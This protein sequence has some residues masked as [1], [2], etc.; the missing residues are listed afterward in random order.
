M[1]VISDLSQ[2]SFVDIADRAPR[3]SST[4][5]SI[6]AGGT[7]SPVFCIHSIDGRAGRYAALAAHID[8]DRPVYGVETSASVPRASS[9]SALA[10]RYADD[11]LAVRGNGPINLLGVSFGGLLAHAVAVALQLGGLA[12]NSLALLGSRRAGGRA[13][14]RHRRGRRSKPSRGA[15]RPRHRSSRAGEAAFPRCLPRQSARRLDRGVRRRRGV[16]RLRQRDGFEVR[17]PRRIGFR[18]RRAVGEPAPV[19]PLTRGRFADTRSGTGR[20]DRVGR[21]PRGSHRSG[22]RFRRNLRRPARAACPSAGAHRR[23]ARS[24][25]PR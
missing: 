7:R 13:P 19:A 21:E 5:V 8:G 16:A 25:P 11:I 6:R 4:V 23:C 12:V 18:A 1:T 22:R 20:R 9:V 14:R 2:F 10:E 17:G 15:R 24:L 3:A